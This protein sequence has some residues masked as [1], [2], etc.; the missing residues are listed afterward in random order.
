MRFGEP[1][2]AAARIV[3]DPAAKLGPLYEHLREMVAAQRRPCQEQAAEALKRRDGR[4]SSSSSSNGGGGGSS[5]GGGGGSNNGVGSSSNGNSSS[6]DSNGLGSSSS[7]SV[8][9]SV[10]AGGG[11]EVMRVANLMGSHGSKAVAVALLGLGI[12]PTIVDVSQGNARY[13]RELA[14][15]GEFLW[16][17]ERGTRQDEEVLR[18]S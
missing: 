6:N 10:P 16:V 2:A 17:G 11:E 4:T 9:G 7:P 12:Q 5:I 13:A 18:G 15:A 1:E 3:A 8:E 14:E